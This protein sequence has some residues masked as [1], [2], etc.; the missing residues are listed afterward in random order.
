MIP[1]DALLYDIDLKLN[2]QATN[3]HQNIPLEDKIIALNQAQIQLIKQKVDINNVYRLG[4]DAFKKRYDDLQLLITEKSVALVDKNTETHKF[5]GTISTMNPKYMFYVDGFI[6]ANKGKCQNRPLY[7]RL[8]KHAD[9]WMWLNN[10]LLRP[11][12][13]YEETIGTISSDEF[14]VYTDGSFT[15]TEVK[16]TYIRYPN[17]IDKSGY[18]DFDGSAS[19]DVDCELSEYLMDELVDLAVK[20]LAMNTAN[21]NAVQYTQDRIMNNE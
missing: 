8:V 7:L 16:I 2:K 13:E 14:E 12:F 1:V 5:S 20:E 15:P 21:N 17:K 18:I 9:L 4:I 19:T 10:S 3:E 11:S 6:L